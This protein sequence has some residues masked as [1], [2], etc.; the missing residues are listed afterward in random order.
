MWLWLRSQY[1]FHL[2]P[3][4]AWRSTYWSI[5]STV[6][7]YVHTFWCFVI[8]VSHLHCHFSH[9]DWLNVHHSSASSIIFAQNSTQVTSR[10]V[11]VW[12][13]WSWTKLT[14]SIKSTWIWWQVSTLLCLLCTM[15]GP[16]ND[17]DPLHPTVSNIFTHCL[18]IRII[19]P[20]RATFWNSIKLLDA[21]LGW[22]SEMTWL[23]S[24]KSLGSKTRLVVSRYNEQNLI[25]IPIFPV[26]LARWR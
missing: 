22:W 23:M 16:Q 8:G 26:W 5:S 4:L 3:K 17:A 21:T 7:W 11:H 6:T 20:W 13:T 25:P 15:A 9:F 10:N 24:F 14:H 18:K 19:G 1:Q 2:L 12:V